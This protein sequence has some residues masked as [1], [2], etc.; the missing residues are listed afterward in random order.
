[1]KAMKRALIV[2]AVLVCAALAVTVSVGVWAAN[3]PAPKPCLKSEPFCFTGQ[4]DASFE[5]LES[6]AL[7]KIATPGWLA[8]AQ[9]PPAPVVPVVTY[10]VASRGTV[11][12]DLNEF[13]AQFNETLNSPNGWSRLGVRFEQVASG[14]RFTAWLSEAS[15]MTSFSASG[16]DATV[17]CRVGNNVVIN[18][19]RWQGGSD[20]WNAAGGSLRDYRHMVVSHETGHWLGHGHRSCS[21]AGNPAPV[22]Q[23]QTI[24]M[25]GCT[26]NP[27]PLSQELYSP[28]LGIRS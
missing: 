21:G 7:P 5:K 6:V 13:A 9:A 14:G 27:W 8:A 25:Q 11:S 18:E 10:N 3:T 19:T 4:F 26:P 24:D 16:C 20:A 17:S 22:M 28:T 12:A 15:Q 23:Q 1:M 2:L